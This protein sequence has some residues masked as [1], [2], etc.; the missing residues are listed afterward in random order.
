[1]PAIGGT[2][3][4]VA[5]STWVYNPVWSR[6][7]TQLACAVLDSDNISV[8]IYTLRTHEREKIV[9]PGTKDRRQNLNWSPQGDAF[10]YVDAHSPSGTTSRGATVWFVR[11][12]DGVGWRVT[13]GRYPNWAPDGRKLYF[14]SD[15]GGTMDLWQ[16]ALDE[17]RKPDGQ[18]MQITHGLGMRSAVFSPDGRRLAYSKGREV[19]NI[20]RAPVP[21]AAGPLL[22]WEAAQ[23]ITFERA[24]IGGIDVSPDGRRIL[25]ASDRAGNWDLWSMP[26][27]GGEPQQLTSDSTA[28]YWPRLS[29]DGRTIAFVTIRGGDFEHIWTMPSDGG[30]AQQVTQGQSGN[31]WPRWSPDGRE[32]AFASQRNRFINIWVTPASGGEARQLTTGPGYDDHWPLWWPDGKWIAFVS[33][34]GDGLRRIWR[35]PLA[36]GQPEPFEAPEPETG[37]NTTGLIWSVDET[38]IY[39]TRYFRRKTAN[40]GS[41]WSL[42]V[43]DRSAR[44]LTDFKGRYGNIGS[45]IATDGEYLY[46]IWEEEIGDIWVM[47]V[48]RE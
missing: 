28:E 47:D 7:G 46:F 35:T 8:E 26:A 22:T 4:K 43:K 3:D 30:P 45:N 40:I 20:W 38:H 31:F 33:S 17:E 34:R 27:A 24:R 6:D 39:F 36:G 37:G 14:I 10:A 23:Q 2:A 9:L 21:A 12:A 19:S 15:R 13:N 11:M 5:S 16:I 1:M 32:I 29:P 25:F 44:Q 41:I 48:E 18:P 42:S